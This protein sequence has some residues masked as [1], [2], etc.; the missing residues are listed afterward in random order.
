MRHADR[1]TRNSSFLEEEESDERNGRI[2]GCPVKESK[3]KRRWNE[4]KRKMVE[5]VERK[6][7]PGARHKSLWTDNMFD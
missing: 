4:L 1:Q 3:K 2:V 5:R 7:S 6:S